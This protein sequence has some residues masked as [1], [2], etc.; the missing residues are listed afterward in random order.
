MVDDG[1]T[2]HGSTK[3]PKLVVYD[4]CHLPTKGGFVYAP[5][6]L[7]PPFAFDEMPTTPAPFIVVFDHRQLF[8]H[9]RGHGVFDRGLSPTF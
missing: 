3:S 5:V 4:R 2:Q 6:L 9:V 7:V 1:L 8:G